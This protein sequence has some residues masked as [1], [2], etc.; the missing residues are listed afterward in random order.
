[1]SRTYAFIIPVYNRPQ[2]IREL[3]ESF[4]QLDTD[5]DY[6]IVIVEDGSTLTCKR[7]VDDFSTQLNIVYY[8]K[9]NSGPGDSRNFGMQH[10]VADYY[11]ILDSDVI[12][13]QYYLTAVSHFLDQYPVNCFGGPDA[14]HSCFTN[15]Q[16]AIDFSMTSLLTTGGIRGNKHGQTSSYEP[17]SFNMGLSRRAFLDSSGFGNIHPGEDPDLSL[18]LKKLGYHLGFIPEAYVYHKRRI[19]LNKF[20]SQVSKF[21]RVRPI[22]MK[23]HPECYK[24]TFAFPSVFTFGL[25]LSLICTIWSWIPLFIYLF[26]FISIFLVS[27][28]RHRSVL[29]GALTVLAVIVQFGGYGFAFLISFIKIIILNKNPQQTYPNL[30]FQ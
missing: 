26:Y 30:F 6:T 21:G 15:W 23:W 29:I 27:A 1:M 9:A 19:D 10:F 13:P 28:S 17:R 16:K 12:L 22:L 4:L 20:Y 5:H 25:L 3:L 2:E 18:R 24:I 11:I 14:A 8:V 7:V